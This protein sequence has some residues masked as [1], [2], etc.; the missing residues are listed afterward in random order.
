[1]ERAVPGP[2][3]RDYT[4]ISPQR[5]RSDPHVA[6]GHRPWR[7]GMYPPFQTEAN[8]TEKRCEM[9]KV[10]ALYKRPDDAQAFNRYYF[11]THVPLAKTL[12][13]LRHYE[14]SDGPVAGLTGATDIFLVAVL[15]F[16]SKEAVQEALT[17]K[18]GQATAA[19]LAN[20]AT[21]GVELIL[22]DTRTV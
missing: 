13:G 14:V 9:A 20:F 7:G 16:D 17:S 5:G 4:E 15:S 10:F 6:S 2:R 21:G 8:K 22:S 18:E 12:P 11:E 3:I 19:D 1:M